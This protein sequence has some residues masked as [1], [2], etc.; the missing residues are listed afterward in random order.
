[1]RQCPRC[2]H[3][4]EG[5]LPEAKQPEPG[6]IADGSI[7]YIHGHRINSTA[8]RISILAELHRAKGRFLT[9]EN[10]LS[11]VWSLSLDPPSK[12][13]VKIHIHNLRDDLESQAPGLVVIESYRGSGY[14]LVD[15]TESQ[16]EDSEH[17]V[18]LQAA[19]KRSAA[20]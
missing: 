15:L 14:R 12:E 5:V 13:V 2:G 9:T 3:F 17:S 7:A 10:L 18:T 20:A 8:T 4:L 11:R 1:M 16:S 19:I 6:F